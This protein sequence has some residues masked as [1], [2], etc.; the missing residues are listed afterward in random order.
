MA[1]IQDLTKEQKQARLKLRVQGGI[2]QAI[3]QLQQSMSGAFHSVWANPELTPQECFDA[4]GTEAKDLLVLLQ[5][6]KA[7]VNDLKAGTFIQSSLKPLTV[8]AD[9]T[10][11]VTVGQ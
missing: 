6:S 7:F 4:F 8:N 9:G 5:K 1:L 3:A 11:T 2:N 10:V